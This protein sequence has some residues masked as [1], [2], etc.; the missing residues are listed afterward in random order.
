MNQKIVN[1]VVAVMKN[2]NVVTAPHEKYGAFSQNDWREYAIVVKKGVKED[3][4]EKLVDAIKTEVVKR[5]VGYVIYK[6]P[7]GFA[8]AAVAIY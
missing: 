4:A 2:E 3:E 6:K 8:D 1:D 5:G 7:K